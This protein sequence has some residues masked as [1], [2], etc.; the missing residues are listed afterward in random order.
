MKKVMSEVNLQEIGVEVN[1]TRRTKAGAILLEIKDKVGAD[2]LAERL[3]RAIG[4]QACIKPLM[5]DLSGDGHLTSRQVV[6][7]RPSDFHRWKTD[8]VGL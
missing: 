1:N 2:L 4:D 8:L 6:S 3:K 5:F 7:G